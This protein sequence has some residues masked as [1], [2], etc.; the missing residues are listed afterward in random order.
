[1]SKKDLYKFIKNK[2][3]SVLLNNKK[4]IHLDIKNTLL[5]IKTIYIVLTIKYLNLFPPFKTNLLKK[6]N[7]TFDLR[8]FF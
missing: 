1:M 5:N 7:I 3:V 6:Q 2:I 8:R 4:K